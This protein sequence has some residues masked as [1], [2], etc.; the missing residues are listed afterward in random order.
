MLRRDPL[1]GNFRA[2]VCE[3]RGYH[4]PFVNRKLYDLFPGW[5]GMGDCAVCGSTCMAIPRPDPP[6][7]LV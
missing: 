7:R 6:K 1:P 4:G 3:D 5:E 2:S